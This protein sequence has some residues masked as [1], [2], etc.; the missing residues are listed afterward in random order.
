MPLAY[1]ILLVLDVCIICYIFRCAYPAKFPQIVGFFEDIEERTK[2][3][4]A[5]VTNIVNEYA[6]LLLTL[7]K[8]GVSQG[9]PPSKVT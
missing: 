3:F 4:Q 9:N 2:N 8:Q 5:G 1:T 6:Q 7:I